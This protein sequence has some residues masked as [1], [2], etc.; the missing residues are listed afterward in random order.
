MNGWRQCN[1]VK[2]RLYGSGQLPFFALELY[3]FEL[4]VPDR[5]VGQL[6]P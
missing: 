2:N 6:Q 3:L 5:L 4:E 1:T